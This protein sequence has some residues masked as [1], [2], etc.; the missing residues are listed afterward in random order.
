MELEKYQ[1]E[2]IIIESKLSNVWGEKL[3]M[4]GA[5]GNFIG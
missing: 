3:N 2:C 4:N 1:N 5:R